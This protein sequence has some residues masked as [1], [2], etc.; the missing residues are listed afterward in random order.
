MKTMKTSAHDQQGAM[1]L[2]A[3]IAILIFSMGILAIVGLQVA[4]VRMSGDAK[5]RTDANMLANKV[6]GQMWVDDR[7]HAQLLANYGSGASGVAYTNWANEVQVTLPGVADEPANQPTIVVAPIAGTN[8]ISSQVTVT[9][10]WNL[11]GEPASSR[12]SAIVIAQIR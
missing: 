10:Y 3:L 12:H 8:T 6:I 7:T 11:P 2:E 9:V 1:L 4:S 5:Y